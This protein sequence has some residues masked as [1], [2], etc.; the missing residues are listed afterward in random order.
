ML[1]GRDEQPILTVF[2]DISH[3]ITQVCLLI[4]LMCSIDSKIRLQYSTGATTS[5]TEGVGTT[6]QCW[7]KRFPLSD[8]IWL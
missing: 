1:R 2:E 3:R 6:S 5:A 7:W 8:W 4:L